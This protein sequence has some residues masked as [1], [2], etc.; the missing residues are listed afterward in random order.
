M[1]GIG[2]LNSL[3]CQVYS[4][5]LARCLD[6]CRVAEGQHAAENDGRP[7]LRILEEM[8]EMCLGAKKSKG[9]ELFFVMGERRRRGRK[10]ISQLQISSG[11]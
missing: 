7:E 10:K 5:L 6:H 2:Q 4:A 8:I 9:R 11:S 3:P 1:A